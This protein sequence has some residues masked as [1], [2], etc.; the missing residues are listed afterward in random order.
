MMTDSAA[1]AIV[2]AGPA[3]IAAALQLERYGLRPLVFEKT[4]PGGLLYDA[5]LVENYPGFPGGISGPELAA[6]LERQLQRSSAI[7]KQRS[8]VSVRL[9]EDAFV[10]ETEGG[11]SICD[12][13]V[14]ASGTAP[15][16][17]TDPGAEEGL[18]GE[19]LYSIGPLRDVEGKTVVVIGSGDAAFD[20]ALSLGSRNEVFIIGRGNESRANASLRERVES[21]RGVNFMEGM[22]ISDISRD[23]R[24]SFLVRAAGRIEGEVRS[25]SADYLVAATGRQPELSFLSHDLL[26]RAD[27]LS[28]KGRMVLA[29]DV[30]NGIFR[31]AA[32]AAGDGVR[33]AMRIYEGQSLD[34]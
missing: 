14:V 9:E 34:G 11:R 2:G 31:Q 25:I 33:A 5:G 13:L 20:Y 18:P 27:E 1:V 23:G 19:V 16:P 29:G 3:G 4:R 21:S 24:G 32:I 17:I 26:G 22:A 10:I 28:D 8:V 30:K 6:L 12:A 15:V 7:L